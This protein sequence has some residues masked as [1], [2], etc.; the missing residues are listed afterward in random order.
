MIG[1]MASGDMASE[2]PGRRGTTRIGL[3]DRLWLV[4]HGQSVG[5]VAH[6]AAA[7]AS[8]ERLE[9]ETR[10]MDVPLSDL[11]REQAG[12]ARAAGCRVASP[13]TSGRP[14]C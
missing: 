5:N 13:C 10:D 8:S 2:A 3:P 11:G 7:A 9:L 6:A 1:D 14:P 4:R 12:G